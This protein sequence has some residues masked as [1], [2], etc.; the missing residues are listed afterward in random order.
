VSITSLQSGKNVDGGVQDYK[1][2]DRHHV[3]IRSRP[4]IPVEIDVF[5]YGLCLFIFCAP[6]PCT[7]TSQDQKVRVASLLFRVLPEITKQF[8]FVPRK[9]SVDF[10][11]MT[12]AASIN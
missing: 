5:Y 3:K 12:T 1:E 7:K 6:L 8:L 11:A 2:L 10:N 9:D 4:S